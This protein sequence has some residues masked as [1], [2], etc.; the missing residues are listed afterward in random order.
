MFYSYF[1]KRSEPLDIIMKSNNNRILIETLLEQNAVLITSNLIVHSDF[2]TNEQL[3]S[4]PLKNR[5]N[6]YF[7]LYD[8]LNPFSSI[9]K[10]FI[11]VLKSWYI[12]KMTKQKLPN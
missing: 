4:I 3:I 10:T 1:V 7:C 9:I 8:P 2:S 6:T 12:K 5:K 11:D